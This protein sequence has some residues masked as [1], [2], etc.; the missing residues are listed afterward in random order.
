M[1]QTQATGQQP[2]GPSRPW[3]PHAIKL[4]GPGAAVVLFATSFLGMLVAAWTGRNAFADAQ[5]VTTCTV[6]TCY[7]RVSGLRGLAVCPPLAFFAGVV[8][9]QMLTAPDT[10]SAAV[11]ILV[12]L[13]SSAPWLFTGTALTVAIALGRGWRAQRGVLSSLREALRD[14]RPRAGRWTT[15]R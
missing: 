11:G 12:T 4:T 15:R 3:F 13:A 7:T 6:V 1:T 5:F 8:L 14:T 9:V 10:L 2:L